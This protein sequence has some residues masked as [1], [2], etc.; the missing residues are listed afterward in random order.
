MRR[1][2]KQAHRV[3]LVFTKTYQLRFEGDEEKR[4]GLGATFE[5][6]I[7]SSRGKRCS[8]NSR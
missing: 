2:V 5:G 3:L 8:V 6:V 4:T 7:F 1:R